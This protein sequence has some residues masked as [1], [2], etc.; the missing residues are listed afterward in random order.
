MYQPRHFDEPQPDVQ[1][2]LIT[3][4]PLATLVVSAGGQLSADLIPLRLETGVG[5]PGTLQGHVARANPLWRPAQ[6]GPLDCL[7]LFQGPSAYVSPSLYPSK[8][9]THKVVPTY[10]Y[11]VVQVRGRLRAIDDAAWLHRLVST[12]TTQFE[13]PRAQ[14]WQVQDAPADYIDTMLRAIVGIEIDIV[15]MTGKY[16]LSQNRDAADHQG[17]MAGLAGD[18]APGAAA[19]AAMM[20]EH[21]RR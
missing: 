11:A 21:G 7:V 19:L 13:Q 20:R 17:A 6:A 18:P 1:H 14:P 10:N 2:A 3:R 12:L 4:Y 9:V 15:E 16:K 5:L 8:A